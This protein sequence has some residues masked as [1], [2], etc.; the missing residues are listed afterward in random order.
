MPQ[1][2][3]WFK[4][5]PHGG[6]CCL[7]PRPCT[8]S[9]PGIVSLCHFPSVTAPLSLCH[10]H[11]VTVFLHYCA[12]EHLLQGICQHRSLDFVLVTYDVPGGFRCRRV[13]QYRSSASGGER[14]G[15]RLE[16]A[17]SSYSRPGKVGTVRWTVKNKSFVKGPLG[18]QELGEYLQRRR[19]QEEPLPPDRDVSVSN[20]SSQESLYPVTELTER[21][22][23][24]AQSSVRAAGGE[25][26][27]TRGGRAGC[28]SEPY[29]PESVGVYS[30]VDSGIIGVY[31]SLPE[32]GDGMDARH[33]LKPGRVWAY[34]DGSFG[35]SAGHTDFT[36]DYKLVVR[37]GQ[38]CDQ[39]LH[40]LEGAHLAMR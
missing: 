31:R 5:L 28:D 27:I 22:A 12:T 37:Q 2:L 10:C 21:S 23:T 40:R 39:V 33:G 20:H 36:I 13:A 8:L 29:R 4:A 17:T 11:G 15:G 34:G 32:E 38:L 6:S 16:L 7:L 19:F 24:G 30:G 35:Y 25:E 1:P 18:P 14:G 3:R 26:G 9:C